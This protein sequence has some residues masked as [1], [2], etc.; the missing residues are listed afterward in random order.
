M[1]YLTHHATSM[2]PAT[3]DA[4]PPD[5]LRS[6]AALLP[7]RDALAMAATSKGMHNAL[8]AS[9]DAAAMC[10]ESHNSYLDLGSII[11]SLDMLEFMV[12]ELVAR[13]TNSTGYHIENGIS[14]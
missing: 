12:W 13:T 14:N 5:A 3:M 10:D 9:T 1:Q 2:S 7:W 4:L 11:G 6:V 8:V